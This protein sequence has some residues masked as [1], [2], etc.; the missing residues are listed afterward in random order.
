MIS[1]TR[2]W[3]FTAIIYY[4]G[5]ITGWAVTTAFTNNEAELPRNQSCELIAVPE[6]DE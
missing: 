2:L 1:A 3:V 6:G 5:S 4:M